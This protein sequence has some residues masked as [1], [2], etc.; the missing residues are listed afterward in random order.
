MAQDSLSAIQNLSDVVYSSKLANVKKGSK[1]E[2]AILRKQF[3]TNKKMQIASA[4]INGAL[5]VTNIIATVPKADFGVSTA[6]MLVAAASA[7]AASIAKIASTKF[8][9]TGGSS[10]SS[11]FGGSGAPTTESTPI[12]PNNQPTTNLNGQ[13]GGNDNSTKVY[14]TET[15]IKRVIN[16]VNVIESRAQFR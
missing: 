8:D 7:T 5:A 3:E 2:E 1:E 11:S 9:S 4:I 13:G 14:V 6:I 12:N 16:R 15:D 10:S